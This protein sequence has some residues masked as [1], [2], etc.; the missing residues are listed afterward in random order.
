VTISVTRVGKVPTLTKENGMWN[1]IAHLVYLAVC[2]SMGP[3]GAFCFA[4]YVLYL[5]LFKWNK[6]TVKVEVV[7]IPH[8]HKDDDDDYYNSDN[9]ETY[10]RL[11]RV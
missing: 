2:V 6:P 1:V 7:H 8:Y 10:S 9:K 3:A 11:L 4:G 5:F